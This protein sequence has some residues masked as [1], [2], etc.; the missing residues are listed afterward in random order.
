MNKRLKELR[1]TLELSQSSFAEKIGIKQTSY[2]DIETGRREL[3]E[4]NLNLICREYN[5]NKDW[6]RN[7]NGNMFNVE[8][9][10]TNIQIRTLREYLKLTRADFGERIG[11]SGDSINNL[12]RGRVVIKD[13]ILKLISQEFNVDENW[14]R[15]GEGSMFA[16]ELDKNTMLVKQILND[17]ESPFKSLIFDIMKIYNSLDQ[18]SKIVINNFIEQL[19]NEQKSKKSE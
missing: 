13:F 1:N 12:E 17:V 4:R 16:L 5:V 8:F 18:T 6:L 2:S 10:K 11:M 3:T 9:N 7:G 19:K 15:T 14:L